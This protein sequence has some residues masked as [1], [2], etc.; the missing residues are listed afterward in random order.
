MET[1]HQ[2]AG[3][4]GAVRD[5]LLAAALQQFTA[6]GYAATTVREIVEAAGVTK[7]SLYYYFGNKEGIYRAIVGGAMEAFSAILIELAAT[8]G[9]ARERILRICT[10][11]F[12][13]SL[14]S[15]D[16]VRL[17][18]AI[19]FGPAQGAPIYNFDE[20]YNRLLEMIGIALEEGMAAGEFRPLPVK[21][22]AWGIVGIFNTIIE[23][24]LCRSEPRIGTQGL[25]TVVT[26][27]LD[28]IA[29]GETP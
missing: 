23:E 14:A 9:P 26:I 6:R 24:Q 17:M 20:L 18:Y 11:A 8:K 15:L 21:E 5:R 13:S 7:P 12:A 1:E 3:M 16:V 19:H 29:Q 10:C 2:A 22:L 28:G 25:E 27:F 4:D